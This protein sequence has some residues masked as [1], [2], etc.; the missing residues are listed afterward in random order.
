MG[1]RSSVIDLGRSGHN[2]IDH[3]PTDTESTELTNMNI[4]PEPMI[5]VANVAKLAIETRG[6]PAANHSI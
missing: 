6:K 1:D 4:N 3:Q 2:P 5:M